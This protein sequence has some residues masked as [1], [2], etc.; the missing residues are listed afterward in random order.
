MVG[1]FLGVA[2]VHLNV[3]M[4]KQFHAERLRSVIHLVSSHFTV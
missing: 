4:D 1:D 3:H 2:D